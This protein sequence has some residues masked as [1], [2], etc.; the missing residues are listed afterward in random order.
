MQKHNLLIKKI[1]KQ[2]FAI[3]DLLEN[4]FNKLKNLNQ[5]NLK[6]KF[7]QHNKLFWGFGTLVIL[8]VSYFLA[9]TAYDRPRTKQMIKDQLL[10]K[11]DI[12][13]KFNEKITYS[14]LPRPHFKSKNL[15]IIST[16]KE[17]ANIENFKIFISI[18]RLFSF[19]NFEIKDV[20]FN[21][22]EFFFSKQDYDFF[23]KFLSIEPSKNKIVISNSKIFFEDEDNDVLFINKITNGKFFYD[24][25]NLQNVFSSKQEIFNIPYNLEI[26]NDKFNKKVLSEFKSKKIRLNIKNEIDY[27]NEKKKGLLEVLLINKN[28]KVDYEINKESLNFKSASSKNNYE[29]SIFFKPF[30]LSSEINYDNLNTKNLFS[31]NSIFLELVKNE[32]LTNK[33][34]NTLILINVNDITNVDEL[35]NL[36]LKIKIQESSIDL[37]DSSI[38]WK[39]DLK[40][41]FY[42]TILIF[43]QNKINL[44]GRM[45]L[46]FENVIDFYKSFQIKKTARKKIKKIELDFNY[47]FDNNEISFDNVKIDGEPNIN[48]QKY[49]DNF[50]SDK[51]NKFNKII[52]KNF[53]NNF[54]IS[55]VG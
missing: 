17:I 38:M 34:L 4:F 32:I 13:I 52:F 6:A 33:N 53:V 51:S 27:N 47:N 12:T 54:F 45:E 22:S 24:S 31:N 42:E 21:K 5:K 23:H 30:Y 46:N 26:K 40:I 44:V 28:T 7:H 1:K 43:E 18:D 9:P 16:D 55:Y 15:S 36:L 37:S 49:I 20:I 3:N 14:L 41:K 11:Y 19:K 25:N 29:G 8:I 48:V 39:D 2:I 10:N 50:L 35:N